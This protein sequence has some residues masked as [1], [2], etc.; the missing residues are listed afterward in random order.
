MLTSDCEVEGFPDCS[1]DIPVQI[2]NGVCN[3]GDYNTE[4]C[5]YD[6]GDCIEWNQKFPDCKLDDLSFVANGLCDKESNSLECGWDGGDCL[7]VSNHHGKKTSLF[8][9]EF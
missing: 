6:G 3:G 4:V 7:G 8:F 9:F 5:G 2:G 1:V